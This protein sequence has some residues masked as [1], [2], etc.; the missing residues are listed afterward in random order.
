MV[1]IIHIDKLAID[2][3]PPGSEVYVYMKYGF[4]WASQRPPWAVVGISSSALKQLGAIYI[5]M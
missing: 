2:V 1:K 4:Y 5:S 3:N